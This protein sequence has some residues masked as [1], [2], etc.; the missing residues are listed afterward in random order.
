MQR[1]TVSLDAATAALFDALIAE[2]GYHSRSK[3]VGDLVLA[4]VE[5]RRQEGAAGEHCVASLS[6]V[7]NH[8]TRR[9]AQRLQGLA[10]DHHDLVVTR[11]HA[12]LDHD[13]TFETIILKG[14][15]PAVRAFADAIRAERGVNFAVIN[16][17][18]VAPND[19]HGDHAGHHHHH[20]FS[21]R[22]PVSG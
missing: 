20:G 3:A 1:V 15:T 22:S 8:R 16:L 10:H 9:L 12:M 21:H 13:A 4:A 2:Q 18:S 17:V 7:Y 11:T 14:P 5:Q 6:Y 19:D